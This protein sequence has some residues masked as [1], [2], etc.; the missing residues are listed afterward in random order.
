MRLKTKA[1]IRRKVV[2]E[3]SEENYSEKLV[4]EVKVAVN[5]Y[6]TGKYFKGTAEEVIKN[7]RDEANK[8]KKV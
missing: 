1:K 2:G 5:D 8:I 3:K 6:K 4:K 7:L